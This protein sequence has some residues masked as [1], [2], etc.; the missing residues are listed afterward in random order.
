[1]LPLCNEAHVLFYR[2]KKTV[3]KQSD[4]FLTLF[5]YEM[6]VNQTNNFLAVFIVQQESPSWASVSPIH[7][8]FKSKVTLKS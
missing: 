5:F 4:L 3:A 8:I 1:M 6:E 7:L 2:E